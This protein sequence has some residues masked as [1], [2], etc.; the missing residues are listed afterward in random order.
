MLATDQDQSSCIY[1]VNI[2]LNSFAT[3]ANITS[4]RV[5]IQSAM[6]DILKLSIV[7]MSPN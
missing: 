3:L 6:D 1:M 2:V 7:V 5:F 4:V